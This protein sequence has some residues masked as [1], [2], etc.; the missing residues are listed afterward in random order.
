MVLSD[1]VAAL[2][3]VLATAN[4]ISVKGPPAEPTLLNFRIHR[5]EVNRAVTRLYGRA[6]RTGVAMDAGERHL[7]FPSEARSA[8]DA[9]A[10]TLRSRLARIAS[11]PLDQRQVEL[12]LRIT[13]AECNRWTKEGRL[14]RSGHLIINRGAGQQR[15]QRST[16]CPDGIAE[17][18]AQSDVIERWRQQELTLLDRFVTSPLSSAALRCPDGETPEG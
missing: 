12:A 4:G 18:L 17:L 9:F 10:F 11:R 14:P 6:L 2:V 3:T 1:R 16:F 13:T 15:V 7:T 8:A 5:R